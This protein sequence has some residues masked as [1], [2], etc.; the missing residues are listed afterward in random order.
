MLT[1]QRGGAVPQRVA[2]VSGDAE[3]WQR[4]EA[5]LQQWLQTRGGGVRGVEEVVDLLAGRPQLENCGEWGVA[6]RAPASAVCL[7]QFGVGLGGCPF[8]SQDNFFS[9]SELGTE[10]RTLCVLVK[11]ATPEPHPQPC[12]F[13]IFIF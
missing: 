1:Q 8:I 4:V 10:H 2:L 6:G 7:H 12:L 5:P 3:G 9:F 11:E 13:F